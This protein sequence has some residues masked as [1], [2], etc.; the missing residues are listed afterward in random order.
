MYMFRPAGL[1]Y[2]VGVIITTLCIVGFCITVPVDQ[3][4]SDDHLL[5]RT[6]L[7]QFKGECVVIHQRSSSTLRV[8]A[9][10]QSTS[11]S[12]L[13]GRGKRSTHDHDPI[14]RKQNRRQVQSS[15]GTSQSYKMIFTDFQAF[16]A[17]DRAISIMVEAMERLYDAFAVTL[18]SAVLMEA[19]QFR[20]EMG[21]LMLSVFCLDGYLS[22]QAIKA[23]VR[24]LSQM[25]QAG[26]T[27]L[28]VG[29]VTDVKTAV[30][31]AFSLGVLLR[32]ERG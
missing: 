4:K 25:A 10:S 6:Q 23:V 18:L 11:L 8:P 29:E 20:I 13:Q 19:S 15:S 28:V 5:N 17:S 3:Y 7:E 16:I 32:E 30:R 26:M 1:F 27:G 24:R 21:D 31:I 22:V 2:H 9:V 14:P 12:Q